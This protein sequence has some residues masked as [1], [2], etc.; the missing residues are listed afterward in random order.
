MLQLSK[1]TRSVIN[2]QMKLNEV[3]SHFISVK[4]YK[5][6]TTVNW[7]YRLSSCQLTVFFFFARISNSIWF[8]DLSKIT[9]KSENSVLTILTT[10]ARWKRV[11]IKIM[12]EQEI[13]LC[14]WGVFLYFR[15]KLQKDLLLIINVIKRHSYEYQF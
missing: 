14:V 15:W 11:P 4:D 7:F 10:F 1:W 12:I 5:P 9:A 8:K 13:L 6:S 3:R 2:N